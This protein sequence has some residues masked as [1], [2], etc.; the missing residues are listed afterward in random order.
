MDRFPDDWLTALWG[1][2]LRIQRC[3]VHKLRNLLG[4]APRHLHDELAEDYHDM[5][6]A[7]T[8]EEVQARRN[9]CVGETVHWTVS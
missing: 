3:T 4:H 1:E 7:G 6:Y 2:E 9:A 5:I 8:A